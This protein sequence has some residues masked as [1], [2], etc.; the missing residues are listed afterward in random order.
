M[1]YRDGS[2]TCTGDSGAALS[3][4]Q[5]DGHRDIYFLRGIVSIGKASDSGCDLGF[6]TLCTNIQDYIDFISSAI[7]NYPSSE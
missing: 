1:G 6:Y 4:S 3:F 2:G 7:H 5:S